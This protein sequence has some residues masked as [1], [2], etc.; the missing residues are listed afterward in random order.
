MFSRDSQI[1]NCASIK[2][3]GDVAE[4]FVVSKRLNDPMKELSVSPVLVRFKHELNI[5]IENKAGLFQPR[6]MVRSFVHASASLVE[7]VGLPVRRR[8][9][10]R[11][12]YPY[13]GYFGIKGCENREITYNYADIVVPHIWVPAAVEIAR[14]TIYY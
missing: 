10:Y 4:K 13:E 5:A 6:S 2:E 1:L 7:S 12:T 3:F 8:S 11:V 14:T 9:P